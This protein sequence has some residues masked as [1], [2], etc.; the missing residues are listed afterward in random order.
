MGTIRKNE[1]LKAEYILIQGQYEAFDQRALSMKALATP[2]LGA[3]VAFGV[4]ES[5]VAI[6][7]ATILVA[8][9]LWILEATWKLFQYCLADRIMF[10]EAWFRGDSVVNGR[11]IRDEEA[12][13][14]I[15]TEWKLVFRRDWFQYLFRRMW[16]PFVSLPYIIVVGVS[17]AII[18]IGVPERKVETRA[19][20]T[21][22]C[23]LLEQG[24]LVPF[25]S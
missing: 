2:L 13:F 4:K 18:L 21:V 11:D 25:R 22:R 14:Q 8:S 20:G 6:L 7:Y 17:L 10:L 23:D 19:D 15:Y 12:P 5:S 1:E 16:A 9:S 3:G 24:G